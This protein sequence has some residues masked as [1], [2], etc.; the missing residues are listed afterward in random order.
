MLVDGGDLPVDLD[1]QL[2]ADAAERVGIDGDALHFHGHEDRQQRTL[3]GAVDPCLAGGLEQRAELPGE[4]E[5]D[6]GILSGVFREDRQ[7]DGGDVQILRCAGLL[8]VG[9][10]VERDGI[11]LDDRAGNLG[12]LDGGVAEQDFRQVVHRVPPVGGDEGIGQHCVKERAGDFDAVGAQDGEVELEV[13]ADF[14]RRGVEDRAEGCQ[15]GIGVR[16]IPAFVGFPGEGDAEQLRGMA[17]EA[18][19]LDVE[20][21][22]RLSGE[23]GEKLGLPLGRVGE[24]VGVRDVVEGFEGFENGGRGGCFGR[25]AAGNCGHVIEESLREGAELELIEEGLQRLVIAA[26]EDEIVPSDFHGHIEQDGG[27]LLGEQRLVGMGLDALLLLALQPGGIGD[28]IL[29]R[30]EFGDELFR[31]FLADAGDPGDV[32]RRVTPQ[33]KDVDDL[34]RALDFPVGEHRGQVDDLILRALSPGLPH[35]GALGNEL[36][37]ILV[38][39]DHEGL[40]TFRLGAFHEGAD[41]VVR[42]EAIQLQH[43]DMEGPA[44][45]FHMRNRGGELFRH[46]VPLRLVGRE[47]DV[48]RGG[49]RGIERDADV[50]G[51]LFFEDEEQGI[52]EPVE[53]GGVDTL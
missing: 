1:L 48:P 35:R 7:R 39:R 23:L 14:F 11:V 20:T 33:A 2:L 4:L 32:V 51:G 47:K 28:E 29:D 52:D 26:G 10:E 36:R 8:S 15:Q 12:K 27:E 6:V 30:A 21:E 43:R 40:E 37:E 50:R 5:G 22:G 42:L 34:C 44:Q 24:L 46:G 25:L 17:V 9:E 38:R 45:R 19:G 41:D 18:G 16:E 31:R 53:R 49:R 13:V 3:D